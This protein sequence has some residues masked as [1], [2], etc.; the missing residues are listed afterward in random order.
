MLQF[1]NHTVTILKDE[2]QP[3]EEMTVMGFVMKKV[4][5]FVPFVFPFPQNLTISVIP[6]P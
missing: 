2:I 4:F 5:S 3:G 6:P 1:P